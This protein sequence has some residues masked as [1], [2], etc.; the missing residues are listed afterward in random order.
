M[1]ANEIITG[2]TQIFNEN[3]VIKV[4]LQGMDDGGYYPNDYRTTEV[5]MYK[6]EDGNTIIYDTGEDTSTV[7]DVIDLL[8]G[9]DSETEVNLSYGD[10]GGSYDGFT[11]CFGIFVEEVDGELYAVFG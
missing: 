9:I 7:T 6:D 5:D 3:G 11:D 1:K 2:L 10:S 8:R 4:C